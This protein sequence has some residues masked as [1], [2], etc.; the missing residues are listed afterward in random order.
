MK[1]LVQKAHRKERKTVAVSAPGIVELGL[2]LAA[3]EDKKARDEEK[4]D[5]C[6]ACTVWLFG[7]EEGI[8]VT[9]RGAYKIKAA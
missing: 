2:Q 5:P 1:Y 6:V 9:K 4:H 8:A 7:A 3:E